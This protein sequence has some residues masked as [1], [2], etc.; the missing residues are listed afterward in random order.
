[1]ASLF[2]TD[3]TSTSSSLQKILFELRFIDKFKSDF[4]WIE[5]YQCKTHGKDCGGKLSYG[6][7]AGLYMLEKDNI[8]PFVENGFDYV[9]EDIRKKIVSKFKAMIYTKDG[10]WNDGDFAIDYE[11]DGSIYGVRVMLYHEK[12][13]GDDYKVFI[14][15]AQINKQTAPGHQLLK[16]YYENNDDRVRNALNAG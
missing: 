8:I 10:V 12:T 1:M 14:G 4:S 3:L 13:D 7:E 6:S 15:I 16:D 5:H 11:I 2:I 9:Q